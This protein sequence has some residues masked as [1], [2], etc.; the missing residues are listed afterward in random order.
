MNIVVKK[1]WKTQDTALYSTYVSTLCFPP[2]LP[3]ASAVLP[4]ER[5]DGVDISDEDSDLA[6]ADGEGEG[7]HRLVTR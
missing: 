6:D 7:A 4:K 2:P 1:F 3:L 5:R